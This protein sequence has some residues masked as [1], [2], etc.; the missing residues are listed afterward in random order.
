VTLVLDASVALKWYVPEEH[1]ERA[2]EILRSGE[3]LIA[4]QIVVAE[5]ANASWKLVRR[6]QLDP[7]QLHRIAAAIARPFDLL[8]PLTALLPRAAAIALE[9]DHPIY[10]CFYLALGEAWTAPLVTDDRR[11]SPSFRRR[12]FRFRRCNPGNRVEQR[13]TMPA[14]RERGL[15]CPEGPLARPMP[16]TRGARRLRLPTTPSMIPWAGASRSRNVLFGDEGEHS[17]ADQS[18]DPEH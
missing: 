12:R 7:S 9:L 18:T 13:E 8:V 4:P 14:L 15:L 5:V 11:L 16:R 3:Q 17:A 6:G 2:Q 10:D 1:A